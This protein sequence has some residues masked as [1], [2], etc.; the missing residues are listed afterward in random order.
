MSLMTFDSKVERVWSMQD[1][2]QSTVSASSV[3]PR[4]S[5]ELYAG[6]VQVIAAADAVEAE[7][8]GSTGDQPSI[9]VMFLTGQTPP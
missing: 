5:T 2:A 7:A 3:Q 9:V 4:G 1:I 8:K 6:M